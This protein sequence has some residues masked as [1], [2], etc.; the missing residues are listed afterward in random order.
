MLILSIDCAN[1]SVGVCIIEIKSNTYTTA[2]ISQHLDTIYTLLQQKLTKS[3]ASKIKSEIAKADQC[4]FSKYEILYLNVFDL[5]PGEQVKD[6]PL[7]KRCSRLKGML[8]HIDSLGYEFDKV[9]VETQM[10]LNSKTAGVNA[11]IDYHYTTA[12]QNIKSSSTK[13]KFKKESLAEDCDS[14]VENVGCSLKN[15]IC[16]SPELKHSNFLS[17]YMNP[18]TG[19]KAHCKENLKYFLAH[20]K[21]MDLLAGIK[22]SNHDDVGDAF[23][24]AVSWYSKYGN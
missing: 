4:L 17:K 14:I 10:A 19:N 15:K 24:Q 2:R 16:F 13:F 8:L 9:L 11:I 20:E 23:M 22:K 7:R 6:V 3:T 5:T 1:K 18:Y 12:D 21:R